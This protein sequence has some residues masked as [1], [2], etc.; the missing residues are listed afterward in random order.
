MVHD[1]PTLIRRSC[2][3]AAAALL[4]LATLPG[5]GPKPPA[6]ESEPQSKTQQPVNSAED[7]R[8]RAEQ[9]WTARVEE[10]WGTVYTLLSPLERGDADPDSF[11]EWA[12][13]NE[14]FRVHDYSIGQVLTEGDL[15]WVEV[16]YNTSIR[17][18]D[19]LPPRQA[20]QWEKWFVL[21]GVWRPI[22]KPVLDAYPVSPAL[23]DTP[24]EPALTDRAIQACNARV[25]SD[26]GSLY[27]LLD[28]EDVA[29]IA[30][31][32]FEASL[33]MVE[34]QDC[35]VIWIEAIAGHGRVRVSLV[36]KLL[37]PSLT[38]LPPENRQLT[39]RWIQRDGIWY[40]DLKR[41][42]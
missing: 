17:Q 10:D 7:L 31:E 39:E 3:R 19:S 29:E 25:Q 38:K 12:Q 35:E 37:D 4:V 9:L 34:Y 41:P 26:W 42:E 14:P 6:Q 33:N 24:A 1:Y 8:Q 2:V 11:A 32:S 21:N 36:Q 20:Q 16:D 15:G 13:E 27:D 5:C 23:R 22:P 18:F 40:L 30:F 28:P